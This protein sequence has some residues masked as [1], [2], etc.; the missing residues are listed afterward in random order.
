M[1]IFIFVTALSV[2]SMDRY[3]EVTLE[4]KGNKC[5]RVKISVLATNVGIS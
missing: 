2:S 5:G 4:R 3:E 1:V